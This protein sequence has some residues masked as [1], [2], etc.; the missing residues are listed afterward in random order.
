MRITAFSLLGISSSA[1]AFLTDHDS[2]IQKRSPGAIN[3]LYQKPADT[4][5]IHNTIQHLSTSELEAV[6]KLMQLAATQSNALTGNSRLDQLPMTDALLPSMNFVDAIKLKEF[7]ITETDIIKYC[8]KTDPENI[9]EYIFRDLDKAD[10]G[11]SDDTRL[12]NLDIFLSDQDVQRQS[13]YER[14]G[15]SFAESP[16]SVFRSFQLIIKALCWNGKLD[17]LKKV[18][19]NSRLEALGIMKIEPFYT[20]LAA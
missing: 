8:S 5:M 19:A 10:S 13:E 3:H 2:M 9:V 17:L 15:N 4:S 14:L 20:R 11:I 16:K 18:V 6:N 1:N 7:G 12:A